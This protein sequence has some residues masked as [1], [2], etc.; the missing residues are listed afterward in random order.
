MRLG[1]HKKQLYRS[2]QVL[3]KLITLFY[4]VVS[5]QSFPS[6]QDKNAPTG[7]PDFSAPV[8]F[9]G[10][11]LPPN[12]FTPNPTG[13]WYTI[14]QTQYYTDAFYTTAPYIYYTTDA[15]QY[16]EQ[17]T[18][19]TCDPNAQVVFLAQNSGASNPW[20]NTL[21]TV[22]EFIDQTFNTTSTAF[23]PY[24]RGDFDDNELIGL[25]EFDSKIDFK[26]K[27]ASLPERDDKGSVMRPALNY[28]QSMDLD[29]NR[30]TVLVIFIF[31]KPNTPIVDKLEAIKQQGFSIHLIQFG[32]IPLGG[33][34][35]GAVKNRTVDFYDKI[36]VPSK[37]IWSRR[38]VDKVLDVIFRKNLI[39]NKPL[40]ILDMSADITVTLPTIDEKQTEIKTDFMITTP[41]PPPTFAPKNNVRLPTG[42]PDIVIETNDQ[43][44]TTFSEELTD[45]PTTG[46]QILIETVDKNGVRKSKL[47]PILIPPPPMPPPP[48]PNNYDRI[49][50]AVK[51][52]RKDKFKPTTIPVLD[53]D[54]ETCKYYHRI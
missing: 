36:S 18:Q 9:L 15:G 13:S 26:N 16:F 29:K 48:L 39:C 7:P 14:Q 12:R 46:P 44:A 22:G 11:E 51:L 20:A 40:E 50:R 8:G 19:A 33:E 31:S 47:L 38:N 41:Q 5:P 43:L 17:T 49:V 52:L 6:Q 45:N 35:D 25:D 42:G 28:A 3:P 21:S 10:T 2:F 32:D 54:F 4:A 27:L 37:S 23:L 24:Y 30:R 53:F 1:S 34:I